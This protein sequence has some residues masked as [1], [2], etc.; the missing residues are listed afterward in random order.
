MYDPNMSRLDW[1]AALTLCVMM[2]V[3]YALPIR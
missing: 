3:G 1:L 2:V